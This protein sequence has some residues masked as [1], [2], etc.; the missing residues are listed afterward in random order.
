MNSVME[1]MLETRKSMFKMKNRKRNKKVATYEEYSIRL[2]HKL[3]AAEVLNLKMEHFKKR[4]IHQHEKPNS[5]SSD[6]TSNED[7]N[8]ND[9]AYSSSSNNCLP[10]DQQNVNKGREEKVQTRVAKKRAVCRGKFRHK[11]MEIFKLGASAPSSLCKTKDPYNVCTGKNLQMSCQNIQNKNADENLPKEVITNHIINSIEGKGRK[12]SLQR[13]T[14]LNSEKNVPSRKSSSNITTKDVGNTINSGRHILPAI[15]PEIVSDSHWTSRREPSRNSDDSSVGGYKCTNFEGES[16]KG[17]R[18]PINKRRKTVTGAD[19]FNNP[20]QKEIVTES[21]SLNNNSRDRLPSSDEMLAQNAVAA[22]NFLKLHQHPPNPNSIGYPTVLR[23]ENLVSNNSQVLPP[24]EQ[25]APSKNQPDSVSSNYSMYTPPLLYPLQQN[26]HEMNERP[27]N[28]SNARDNVLN[29]QRYIPTSNYNGGMDTSNYRINSASHTVHPMSSNVNSE[30]PPRNHHARGVGSRGVNDVKTQEDPINLTV[31]DML[32]MNRNKSSNKRQFSEPSASAHVSQHT[33]NPSHPTIWS[34][35]RIHDQISRIGN[36]NTQPSHYDEELAR[37]KMQEKMDQDVGI[38]WLIDN[39]KEAMVKPFCLDRLFEMNRC[40]RNLQSFLNKRNVSNKLKVNITSTINELITYVSYKIFGRGDSAQFRMYT[41]KI[42]EVDLEPQKPILFDFINRGISRS[43]NEVA[44]NAYVKVLRGEA[45]PN[46]TPSTCQQEL[47]PY[48]NF[49]FPPPS[50]PPNSCIERQQQNAAMPFNQIPQL[51]EQ[52]I[53]RSSIPEMYSQNQQAMPHTMRHPPDVRVIP[54]MH[55]QN[56]VIFYQTDNRCIPPTDHV[57]PQQ[58]ANN[59]RDSFQ[60]NF[61]NYNNTTYV[62]TENTKRKSGQDLEEILAPNIIIGTNIIKG[63]PTKGKR[64]K[65]YG[66]KKDAITKTVIVKDNSMEIT[67]GDKHSNISK[68]PINEI[69]LE[70]VQPPTNEKDNDAIKVHIKKEPTEESKELQNFKKYLWEENKGVYKNVMKKVAN[71]KKPEVIMIVDDDDMQIQKLGERAGTESNKSLEQSEK[72]LKKDTPSKEIMIV[73][74]EDTISQ[75]N[76][77]DPQG[78][79]LNQNFID[80]ENKADDIVTVSEAES[81]T[82]SRSTT[83]VRHMPVIEDISS[84]DEPVRPVESLKNYG[85]MKDASTIMESNRITEAI[86]TDPMGHRPVITY[87]HARPIPAVESMTEATKLNKTSPDFPQ[88][89]VPHSKVSH[90]YRSPRE[91]G[92]SPHV[93]VTSPVIAQS[94]VVSISSPA[95]HCKPGMNWQAWLSDEQRRG[96]FDFEQ[97][98]SRSRRQSVETISSVGSD[99][100]PKVMPEQDLVEIKVN[101]KWYRIKKS[102]YDKIPRGKLRYIRETTTFIRYF[103]ENQ[104]AQ[105]IQNVNCN[106]D[107]SNFLKA[108][109]R[110]ERNNNLDTYLGGLEQNEVIRLSEDP[111]FSREDFIAEPVLYVKEVTNA[112]KYSPK[113]FSHFYKFVTGYQIINNHPPIS[114]QTFL[115]F[116]NTDSMKYLF[117]QYVN[118]LLGQSNA[119]KSSQKLVLP[120]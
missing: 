63:T 18:P 28:N 54:N 13:S 99:Y 17:I 46:F 53:S 95:A 4:L 116:H 23:S 84:D 57:Y 38:R 9:E 43:K 96:F 11:D 75:T 21:Q 115:T 83:S 107:T 76:N 31:N 37:V 85:R 1:N 8:D 22:N 72:K 19:I 45:V 97:N 36:C 100:I 66:S 89:K 42:M 74:D 30:N 80:L 14:S 64:D 65:T 48:P 91:M 82:N 105:F 35:P 6:K 120:S 34:F 68:E 86:P 109:C 16:S 29:G 26:Q 92:P 51:G 12:D 59:T 39:A 103:D 70:K 81:E 93:E 20:P 108:E 3:H 25:M 69:I 40:Y 114:F 56:P 73:D 50:I 32:R 71:N 44:I 117:N 47:H 67:K 94:P 110:I 78:R 15:V 41:D 55:Q 33:N 98:R 24:R 49:Q 112:L 87:T 102:L 2:K 106:T 79:D 61:N 113:D 118:N 119:P 77:G 104:L 27:N 60:V 88:K 5:Y 10:N 101:S 52:H 58:P 111:D 90:G 7:N 62:G